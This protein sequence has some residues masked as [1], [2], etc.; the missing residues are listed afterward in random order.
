MEESAGSHRLDAER[1]KQICRDM[2]RA[3]G[4]PRQDAELIADTLVFA[5]L[6]GVSSHGL[7][8]LGSY[9]R[10]VKLGLMNPTASPCVVQKGA[11][12]ALVDGCNGFGQVVTM[13]AMNLAIEMAGATGAAVVGVRNSNHFGAAA[14]YVMAAVKVGMIGVV[15]SNAAPAMAPWGGAVAMMGT[16]PLAIG[17]PAGEE[18][19]VVLDMATSAV[20]R[21]K[22]R[23][24]AKKGERI[25]EGWALNSKG[26]PTTDPQE[27]LAG[28][29]LPAS[30]PKGYGLALVIDVL[31]GILTG[32]GFSRMVRSLDDMSGP[33]RAG[34]LV[35]TINVQAFT[36]LPSFKAE[37][38]AFIREVKDCPKAAGVDRIYLPGEIEFEAASRLSERGITVSDGVAADLKALGAELGVDTMF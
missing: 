3:A 20:A 24:A 30:G 5:E 27:A 4:V 17:I 28:T 38:D 29:L 23:L 25:P 34:H 16:N 11:S 21:G 6:R 9:I 36:N 12:T 22:I 13:R 14:Y 7:V 31:S 2:L 26:E 8:R 37:V 32:S 35:A 18:P 15:L 10:R 1:A 33:V 19:P